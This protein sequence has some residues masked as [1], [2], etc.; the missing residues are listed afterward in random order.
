MLFI[1]YPKCTT[2]IKAKNWLK[3]NNIDFIERD[4]KENNPTKDEIIKFHQLSKLDINKLFNTSGLLY[5]ELNLKEKLK[6][7]TLDEKY[8]LL[9]S[10]GM[11]I[12]RP[13]LVLDDLVL[14]GFKEEIYKNIL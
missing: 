14:F 13:I 6:E 12:K 2:C 7:M 5:K 11:L 9:A 1:C 4:I 8:D 3:S 10:N